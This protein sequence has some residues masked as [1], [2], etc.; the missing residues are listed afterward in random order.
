MSNQKF[1]VSELK[2]RDR[3]GNVTRG[4]DTFELSLQSINNEVIVGR[5]RLGKPIV[6][7]RPLNYWRPFLTA[8]GTIN[9]VPLRTGA[10]FSMHSDALAYEQE[11]RYEL[12][13]AG[14]IPV[15]DCPYTQLYRALTGTPH[16]IPNPT[17]EPD[18]G[19]NEAAGGCVHLKALQA[20][21]ATAAAG[22]HARE[23]E[24]WAKSSNEQK[25]NMVTELTNAFAAIAQANSPRPDVDG[26]DTTA[27]PSRPAPRS[28]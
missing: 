10:V 15:S 25:A 24:E 3:T 12:L 13:M 7:N 21:R 11:T 19:G 5:D 2:P 9:N 1:V 17:N 28:K 26:E 23:A 6:E 27:K 20:E 22:T 18:C 14:W 8:E 4:G 16:L